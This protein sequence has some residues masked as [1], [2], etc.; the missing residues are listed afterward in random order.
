MRSPMQ[1]KYAAEA[2]H[3]SRGEWE[4]FFPLDSTAPCRGSMPQRRR[5]GRAA[6][7]KSF[8]HSIVQPHAEE[9]CRRGGAWVA[10]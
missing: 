9:V 6:S 8:S 5:M 3:G 2:A 7:R 1:R 4:K 10:R